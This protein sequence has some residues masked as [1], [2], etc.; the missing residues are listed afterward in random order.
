MVTASKLHDQ[1]ILLTDLT[2]KLILADTVQ[3][4]LCGSITMTRALASSKTSQ[5]WHRIVLKRY[6]ATCEAAKMI[7]QSLTLTIFNI[8]SATS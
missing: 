6:V 7:K 8:T 4:H 5:D 1:G 2:R 3:I